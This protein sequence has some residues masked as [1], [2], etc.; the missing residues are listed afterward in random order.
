MLI[1]NDSR[2]YSDSTHLPVRMD[3][4]IIKLTP[5]KP[6]LME[7]IEYRPIGIVRS[8]FKEPQGTPIQSASA[9]GVEG[10]VEMFSQYAEGL[11]DL[12]GFSHL[13]L[14]YH[15]HLVS[16]YSL[17]VKPFL[18][19]HQG[20]LFATRS[21]ATES[22]RFFYSQTDE[23]RRECTARSGCGHRGRGPSPGRQALCTSN[24]R[25]EDRENRVDGG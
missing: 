20:G 7:K 23:N 1:I 25:Q 5:L 15:F 19:E 18:D 2:Y 8:P 13:Y 3:N 4:N 9:E 24:G 10:S 22:H 16:S 11:K 12:E 17:T 21:P 14:I 6:F